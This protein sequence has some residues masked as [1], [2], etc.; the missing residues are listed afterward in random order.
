MVD[1]TN[2]LKKWLQTPCAT[3]DLLELTK[4]IYYMPIGAV[5]KKIQYMEDTFDVAVLE[6]NFHHFLFN[7]T[8]RDT[9]ASG[10]IEIVI[11][12]NGIGRKISQMVGAATFPIASYG[13]N[14]HYAATLMSLC[15]VSAFGNKYPQF[16]SGLNKIYDVVAPVDK[17]LA[18]VP[19][20]AID[21][22][23][24]KL[25]KKVKTKISKY[26]FREEAQAY[27]ETTE[28]RFNIECKSIV[29]SLPLKNK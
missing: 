19:A 8:Q 4:G 6:Q 16:G 12:D 18:T 24:E 14:T 21:K 20:A 29:N 26:T 17:P 28:F 25:L 15:K 22:E 3:E 10:S 9:L 27:L 23:I 13:D 5:K 1:M 2:D 7:N 11:V